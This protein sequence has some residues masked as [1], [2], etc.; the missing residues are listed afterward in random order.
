[1]SKIPDKLVGTWVVYKNTCNSG[2]LQVQKL[3]KNTPVSF[4]FIIEGN[5]DIETI[6][7]LNN[8]WFNKKFSYS[9][10]SIT[11]SKSDIDSIQ[12]PTYLEPGERIIITVTES[13]NYYVED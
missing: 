2:W 1:M 4:W 8:G 5:T 7:Q 9:P 12:W 10:E 6:N 11:V 3:N 13:G